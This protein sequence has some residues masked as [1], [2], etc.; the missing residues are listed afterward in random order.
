[1]TLLA[2]PVTHMSTNAPQFLNVLR[3]CD[4]NEALGLIAPRPLA[5]L[6]ANTNEFAGTA[7]IYSAA[8]APEKL[9]FK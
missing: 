3:V 8:A 7:S 4:L 9:S 2:P 1:M 5:I 6:E